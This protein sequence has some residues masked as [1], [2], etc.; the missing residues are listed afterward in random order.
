[1]MGGWGD[2]GTGCMIQRR[3]F[4]LTACDGEGK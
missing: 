4:G 3:C 1:M 2:G